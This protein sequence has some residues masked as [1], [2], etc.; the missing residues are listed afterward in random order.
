MITWNY[1]PHSEL[2][3]T[4]TFNGA[5]GRQLSCNNPLPLL[6]I[7]SDIKL[8]KQQLDHLPSISVVKIKRTRIMF[9]FGSRLPWSSRFT[10]TRE[11]SSRQPFTVLIFSHMLQPWPFQ[12]CNPPYMASWVIIIT[13]NFPEMG[14]NE[15]VPEVTLTAGGTTLVIPVPSCS[16]CPGCK[17]EM[18]NS[19]LCAWMPKSSS[20][21]MV[22]R[23]NA[24]KRSDELKRTC[25]CVLWL[26]VM[27]LL[28]SPSASNN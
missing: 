27:G 22:R 18:L 17:V 23:L 6:P 16:C 21:P 14:M 20:S 25:G 8:S 1:V 9:I 26:L 13:R 15:R 2:C 28:D 3:C 10:V 7:S 19:G 12:G 5:T 4:F 24:G 11:P